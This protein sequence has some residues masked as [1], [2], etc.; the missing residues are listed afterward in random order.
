M[1]PPSIAL[2]RQP[3]EQL[4]LGTVLTPGGRTLRLVLGPGSGLFQ[5]PN[6]DPAE[7]WC[8]TDRGPNVQCGKA[9]RVLGRS[10]D[11]ACQGHR[12]GKVFP[13][14][15]FSPSILRIRL[16]GEAFSV[17]DR[18]PLCDPQR[19][20]LSGLPLPDHA[21][22]DSEPAFD[23]DG[24]R[25]AGDPDGIDIESVVRLRSGDFWL[26]E[27]CGPSLLDVG[28]D[29]IVRRRLIPFG[30][31]A[32]FAGARLA[33]EE[34]LPAIL[35]RRALN[36]GI[37]AIGISADETKL[38]F[39]TQSPL[40]HPDY[41]CF[42]RSR[43]VRL[44]AVA[45]P[46]CRI[47]AEH[48]YVLDTADSFG[49]DRS[50][51]ASDVRIGDLQVLADGTLAVL[52]RIEHTTRIHRVDVAAATDIHGST[53]DDAAHRPALEQLDPGELARNGVVAA[54]KTLLF[55]STGLR[56]PGGMEGLS[57]SA[58]GRTLTLINDNDCGVEGKETTV[59][60]IT[61]SG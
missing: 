23:L 27:E 43:L 19:R 30:T 49:D 3:T 14:P 52:E 20:P 1:K 48:V 53:W 57:I 15:G 59:A 6:S 45:L 31:S 29:G 25:L 4:D 41:A 61:I 2:Y 56:L 8:I 13:L 18:L 32:V 12:Q 39:M 58:D 55:D 54:S 36:R 46:D 9:E 22:L 34:R 51:R 38:W 17:V 26:G 10:I 28:P 7:F 44:F 11:D 21:V 37:E 60:R 47:A 50:T 40:A 42:E 24:N 33:I 35:A 5:P 16:A